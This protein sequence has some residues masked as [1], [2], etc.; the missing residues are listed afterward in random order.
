MRTG[1]ILMLSALCI[2]AA[3]PSFAQSS[4]WDDTLQAA[5][6]TDSKRLELSLGR[7]HTGLE[8]IR[9]VLSPVGEGDPIRWVQGLPGVTTGADGT[10]AMYVRG[11]SSGN[12]LFTL[13][14]VPVYGYSHILGL[15]TLVPTAVIESAELNKGG[16]DGSESNFNAA[17]LLIHTKDPS[18]TQQ[19]SIALNNFLLSAA[20]EGPLGKKLSYITSF[21]ISPLAWE[22]RA[23]RKTLPTM[24][25]GLENFKAGVFD[26]YAKLHYQINDK[27]TLIASFLGSQDRY[28]FNMPDASHEVMGWHNLL[29]IMKYSREGK[30]T[31]ITVTASVNK[32]ETSQEQETI[33]REKLNHLSLRSDLIEYGLQAGM[34][35]KIGRTGRFTLSE[36]LNTRYSFFA[37]GQVGELSKETKT[38]LCTA[39]LQVEYRIPDRLELKVSGRYNYYRNYD[40][41]PNTLAY[42][43]SR[44]RKD[45]EMSVSAKIFFSPHIAL[46]ASYDI[47]RQYYHSLEGLPVG[48][49]LDM[50]VPSGESAVPEM[51]RQGSA[52]LSGTFGTHNFSLG[53]FYKKMENLI[54]YK[55]SQTLFSGALGT[56]ENDI[57]IG[58]GRSYGLEALYEF[59]ESDWYARLSYTLSK[60]TREDFPSFYEGKP[61]HARFDRRHVLNAMAQ[62]KNF[63]AMVILQSG[64]WENGQPE[65]YPMP[66]L[67]DSWIADYYSGVN[68]YHMPTVFR[69]DL[70][71]QKTFTTG[72]VE[73]SVN[74][75]VCNVTNHFNPFMLYFDANTESWKEI[76]LLPILPNFSWRVTF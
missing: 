73:H 3:L 74:V 36:G 13:D 38:L 35:H 52:G 56:W 22:Y 24:F 76:A 47:L 19:T 51:M 32:Y 9:G 65:T 34:L 70:G 55:Y 21:R 75:G 61:F 17:H 33:Y 62:W 57:E 28:G 7:L 46:E 27:N 5:V 67:L 29:G 39:W 49:S 11:G 64:H 53:G 54:Y 66:F 44:E 41:Q 43:E 26:G 72:R 60:T 14:G 71:W 40:I 16:F 18:A 59:Q 58:N 45:P 20:T 2:L 69:L 68:N 31:D 48:W 10:T 30:W 23:V 42:G 50:I 63:T 12:N 1:R 25:G 37:P 4:A 15:T 6:K 8:G